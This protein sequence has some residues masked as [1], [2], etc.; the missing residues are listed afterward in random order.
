M[1]PFSTKPLKDQTGVSL[2]EVLVLVI[3]MSIGLLG[4]AGLQV[5]GVRQTTNS[6]LQTQAMLMTDDLIAR[7]RANR[8]AII[9]GG[10]SQ[11]TVA[12]YGK[13]N[14]IAFPTAAIAACKTSA[15]CSPAQMATT[16]LFN[17]AQ[18][19][20]NSLPVDTTRLSNDTYICLDS[21]STDNTIC[22][23]A[24]STLVIQIGW[25]ETSSTDNTNNI[26]RYQM[27]FEP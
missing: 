13:N 11:I 2:I 26:Q 21:D 5:A 25:N 14:S 16:D 23:G 15:G 22:D 6:G 24:G 12:N 20:Q 10:S 9:Q 8:A 19:V 18:L 4:I 3:I 1:T 7:I 17:W 27:V